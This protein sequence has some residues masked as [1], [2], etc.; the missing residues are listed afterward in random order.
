M[1]NCS[2]TICRAS[3]GINTK[4][5]QCDLLFEVRLY[6]RFTVMSIPGTSWLDINL[7]I[8]PLTAVNVHDFSVPQTRLTPYAWIFWEPARLDCGL[9][10]STFGI[11]AD[12]A[13]TDTLALTWL[14]CSRCWW[15]CLTFWFRRI[16]LIYGITLWG[17]PFWTSRKRQSQTSK[18]DG[19]TTIPYRVLQLTRSHIY[20]YVRVTE[21]YTETLH[22]KKMTEPSS[23][24]RA[25]G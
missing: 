25:D 20:R 7:M 2:H 6:L 15:F 3:S 8:A 9:S 1:A 4:N 22:V 16:D 12:E 23:R 11:A 24:M 18:F 5:Q 13:D 14:L 21:K 19:K 17:I 10:V